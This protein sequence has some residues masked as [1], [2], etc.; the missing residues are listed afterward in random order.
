MGERASIECNILTQ[1]QYLAILA[2]PYI[3]MA[4]LS[5][6]VTRF[7]CVSILIEHFFP[8]CVVKV[9]NKKWGIR[10]ANIFIKNS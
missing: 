9:K 10:I 6:L 2:H 8:V 3:M 1:F 4:S 5:S 7:D